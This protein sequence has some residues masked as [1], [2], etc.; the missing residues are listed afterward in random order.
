MAKLGKT[1]FLYNRKWILL[2]CAAGIFVS[3]YLAATDFFDAETKLC[4]TDTECDFVRESRYSRLGG[5]P[6]SL[7]GLAGYSIVAALAVSRL[8][9]KRRWNLLFLLSSCAV[10]FS[11]YLTYVELFV[12]KAIC[13]WCV[14][15]AS[16]AA[17][18]LAA[19]IAQRKKMTGGGIGGRIIIVMVVVFAAVFAAA[20][21]IQRPSSN[22]FAFKG[23]SSLYQTRLARHLSKI[24]ATMYGSFRCVYCEKQK[25]LFGSAFVYVNYVECDKRGPNARPELC[26]AK[27]IKSYP[28]WE[29]KGKLH[30]G[31]KTLEQMEGLSGYAG[32]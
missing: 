5:I 26:K 7:L 31:L 32:K 13:S 12:I 9:R 14:I 15:S 8:E 1:S 6:V 23:S 18:L 28:T 27:K 24:E 30:Q 29:I 17:L 3:L 11:A 21:A 20:Y 2:L 19:V 25:E 10:G 22:E 16:V 4:L